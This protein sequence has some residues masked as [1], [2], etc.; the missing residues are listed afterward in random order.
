MDRCIFNRDVQ[1]KQ[2]EI[3]IRNEIRQMG[4]SVKQEGTLD[5][6]QVRLLKLDTL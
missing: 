3:Y 4:P 1:L 2:W 5:S 6:R